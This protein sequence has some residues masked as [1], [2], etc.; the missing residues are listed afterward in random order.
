MSADVPEPAEGYHP[1]PAEELRH[2]AT[3]LQEWAGLIARIIWFPFLVL[4]VYLE[5]AFPRLSFLWVV[6]LF[7]CLLPPWLLRMRAAA[8]RAQAA[9]LEPRHRTGSAPLPAGQEPPDPA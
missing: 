1:T 6:G 7:L 2:A 4:T 3:H 9:R 8:L 5:Y